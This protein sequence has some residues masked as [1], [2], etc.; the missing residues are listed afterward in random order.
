MIWRNRLSFVFL[1]V[2][3]VALFYLVG[4]A[5]PPP[6]E[7]LAEAEA[8]V[9]AA[10]EAGAAECAPEE[11]AAAQSA[12]DQGK[13]LASEF[14]AELEARRMLI[15]AKAKADEARFKCLAEEEPPPAPVTEEVGL[16]DIFFDFD[17]SDIR[18]D[19]EPVLQENAELM[20]QNPNLTIVIECYADIRGS[21]Q[22]NMDLAGRRCDSARGHLVDLGVDEGRIETM[23]KGETTQF[24]AGS[25]EEAYQLNR[26]ARFVPM[27]EG[28]SPGARI[29]FK[30]NDQSKPAM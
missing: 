29:F 28:A 16:K 24:G 9:A 10:Q 23:S 1:P 14:C 2:F 5:T 17:K 4:C 13:A 3:V 15:E 20:E 27:Q 19:A 7:E 6:T 11:F 18:P 25:T 30:F 21:D 26:R 12:L 8:A 22:Y